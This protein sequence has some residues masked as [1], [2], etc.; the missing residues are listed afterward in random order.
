[1]AL[2]QQQLEELYFRAVT[3]LQRKL[4]KNQPRVFPFG[5]K[6]TMSDVL[7]NNEAA[8]H[9]PN[10]P[11]Q[12]QLP[13][14]FDNYERFVKAQFRVNKKSGD[15][16]INEAI[17]YWQMD[18]THSFS[19]YH[20]QVSHNIIVACIIR[21]IPNWADFVTPEAHQFCSALVDAWMEAATHQGGFE[22]QEAFLE[23]W[24]TGPYDLMYFG[25]RPEERMREAVKELG[26]YVPHKAFRLGGE[27]PFLEQLERQYPKHVEMFGPA[28]A[29]RWIVE[30]DVESRRVGEKVKGEAA[31]DALDD[32]SF[33]VSGLRCPGVPCAT[34]H[35]LWV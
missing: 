28:W 30:T 23:L 20:K 12:Y 7:S 22:R 21:V 31:Q 5:Q 35:R 16:D 4:L 19:R 34:L 10:I 14:I 9:L 26:Q 29:I 24:A 11:N 25:H 32:G 2:T 1:M 27:Q 3:M 15:M 6:P 13:F 17:F 8:F 18:G 33:M